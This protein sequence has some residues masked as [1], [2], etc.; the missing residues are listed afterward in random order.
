MSTNSPV[1]DERDFDQRMAGERAAGTV[2][3]PLQQPATESVEES[4]AEE[5]R[6][7]TNE[8]GSD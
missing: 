3:R 2:H 5:H 7:A 6:S 1:P 4:V 8:P